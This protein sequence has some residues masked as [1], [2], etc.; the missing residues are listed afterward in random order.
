VAGATAEGA[1]TAGKATVSGTKTVAGATAEGATTAGK[2]TASGTKKVAGA[3]ADGTV[4]GVKAVGHGIGTGLEKA[5]GAIS[6]AGKK[7]DPEKK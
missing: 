2:A 1:T 4:K 3:T 7:V 5:G 6:G